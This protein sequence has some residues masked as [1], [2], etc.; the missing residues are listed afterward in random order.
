MLASPQRTRAGKEQAMP[1]TTAIG[2]KRAQDFEC[3]MAMTRA[4]GSSWYKTVG[5]GSAAEGLVPSLSNFNA[6]A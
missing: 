2:G 5:L 6:S 4:M 3:N 1:A